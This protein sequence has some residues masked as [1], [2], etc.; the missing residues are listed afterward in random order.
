MALQLGSFLESYGAARSKRKTVEAH[1]AEQERV[2]LAEIAK[3]QEGRR[4]EEELYTKKQ[5]LEEKAKIRAEKRGVLTTIDTEKRK[6]KTDIN[7]RNIDYGLTNR[8]DA[9]NLIGTQAKAG[10][11]DENMLATS[12]KMKLITPAQANLYRDTNTSVVTKT[13]NKAD[14]D[15]FDKFYTAVTEGKIEAYPGGLEYFKKTYGH[16]PRFKKPG[17]IDKIGTSIITTIEK[18]AIK[19]NSVV[20]ESLPKN[21]QKVIFPS[22]AVL[23]PNSKNLPFQDKPKD[24]LEQ[25]KNFMGSLTGSLLTLHTSGQIDLNK[26]ENYDI[27]HGLLQSELQTRNRLL[28]TLYGN[29]GGLS[30]WDKMGEVNTQLLKVLNPS[31]SS[32]T[33][34]TSVSGKKLSGTPFQAAKEREIVAGTPPVASTIKKSAAPPVVLTKDQLLSEPEKAQADTS[35]IFSSSSP[36]VNV[37]G[38]QKY[39]AEAG[40]YQSIYSYGFLTAD[41]KQTDAILEQ[42]EKE[43]EL[44]FS[45]QEEKRKYYL[46][47]DGEAYAKAYLTGEVAKRFQKYSSNKNNN[48]ARNTLRQDTV[49]HNNLLELQDIDNSFDAGSA[50]AETYF[51]TLATHTY[52]KNKDPNGSQTQQLNEE[53]VYHTKEKGELKANAKLLGDHTKKVTSAETTL[54]ELNNVIQLIGRVPEGVGT[55]GEVSISIKS[56]LNVARTAVVELKNVFGSNSEYRKSGGI[57]D[58]NGKLLDTFMK[59]A[60]KEQKSITE[61]L[62]NPEQQNLESKKRYLIASEQLS[63]KIRLAYL[64]SSQLQGDG[65]AGGRTISDADFKFALQAVWGNEPG[66]IRTRLMNVKMSLESKLRQYQLSKR[67]DK[68]GVGPTVSRFMVGAGG[69]EET[70]RYKIQEDE[71]N[72]T[73]QLLSDG[74]PEGSKEQVAKG[75]TSFSNHLTN[76]PNKNDIL[77]IFNTGNSEQDV[78]G[79]NLKIKNLGKVSSDYL[80]KQP[81]LQQMAKSLANDYPN[82]AT[83]NQIEDTYRLMLD[84]PKDRTFSNSIE[85]IVGRLNQSFYANN[86]YSRKMSLFKTDDTGSTIVSDDDR[87]GTLLFKNRITLVNSN[88]PQ[89]NAVTPNQAK[90]L[91]KFLMFYAVN[92]LIKNTK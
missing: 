40:N 55:V 41:Y 69:F 3:L 59:N 73:A 92:Q 77:N 29:H 60:E 26:T 4:Y 22:K 7:L 53:Y 83:E 42:Y 52:D 5:N 75:I 68:S 64:L 11:L 87:D 82:G 79:D 74:E 90:T 31:P 46:S 15:G 33:E 47:N 24:A 10:K 89:T 71:R 84:D 66:I 91:N 45:N 76:S 49:F 32:Q 80:E 20:E 62:N 61:G 81:V 48:K 43:N 23:L 86:D 36:D 27:V 8:K 6:L 17:S 2:R 37:D 58:G 38:E 88:K 28:K 35:K 16:L 18:N 57:S 72:I 19:K 9:I 51:R 25:H 34:V 50:L 78:S 21:T 13:V 1:A 56:F 54:K 65:T 44:T 14:K 85:T 70:R 30:S 12:I 63:N 67:Y 39:N